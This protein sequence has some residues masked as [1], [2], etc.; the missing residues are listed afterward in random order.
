MREVGRRQLKRLPVYLR[1][2][3]RRLATPS[4][5]PSYDVQD[6]EAQLHEHTDGWSALR[7][8]APDVQQVRWSLEELRVS[9]YAQNLGTAHPVSVKRVRA[10]LDAL[11]GE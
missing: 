9:L 11:P 3:Q 1:A 2:A 4:A 5:P 7:R 10:L 6:L 8:L